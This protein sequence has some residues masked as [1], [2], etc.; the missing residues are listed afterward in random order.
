MATLE[1]RIAGLE[2][3]NG[4]VEGPKY[5]LEFVD[6]Q[7]GAVSIRYGDGGEIE[8]LDDETEAQF[9]ERAK[10]ERNYVES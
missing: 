7:R 8:R 3:V 4:T 1:R 10:R 6:R 9:L 5:F 2:Q